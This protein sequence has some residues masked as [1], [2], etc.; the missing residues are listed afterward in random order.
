MAMLKIHN[1]ALTQREFEPVWKYLL[2]A[3]VP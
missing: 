1:A 3:P 2:T